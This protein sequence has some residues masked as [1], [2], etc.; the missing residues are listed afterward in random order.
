M[1]WKAEQG[2][3]LN[4]VRPKQ[5]KR[6]SDMEIISLIPFLSK[7]FESIVMDWRVH[8]VGEKLGWSQFGGIQGSSSSHYLIYMITYI[9]Y[10]QDLKE[11]RATIAARQW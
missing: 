2:I 8:F 1:R 11:P 5:P 9:L 3:A 4:K 6:E 10:N 7:A